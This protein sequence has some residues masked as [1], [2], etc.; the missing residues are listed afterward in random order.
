MALNGS[1]SDIGLNAAKTLTL[2]LSTGLGAIGPGV[3]VGYIM[4]KTVEAVARQPELRGELLSLT[5]LG[6]ALTEALGIFA[7][8]IAFLILFAK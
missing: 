4:G 2:G 3:G 5:F 8:V 6:L 1:A 7:L